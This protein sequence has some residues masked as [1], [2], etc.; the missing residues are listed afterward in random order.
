VP[1]SQ[2]VQMAGRDR[3]TQDELCPQD[4]VG[5]HSFGSSLSSRCLGFAAS[6]TRE[7]LHWKHGTQ[8]QLTDFV[9]SSPGGSVG[10]YQLRRIADWLPP[11]KMK[12]PKLQGWEHPEVGDG[13]GANPLLP[14]LLEYCDQ[15]SKKQMCHLKHFNCPHM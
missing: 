13:T 1:A 10:I 14:A 3:W 11:L 12:R 6:L 5:P 2:T 9:Q 4:G 8:S 15:A 7:L